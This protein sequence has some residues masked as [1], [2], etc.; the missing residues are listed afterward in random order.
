MGIDLN[1]AGKHSRTLA[2]GSSDE[3]IF[4][5]VIPRIYNSMDKRFEMTLKIEGQ[6]KTYSKNEFKHS[7]PSESGSHEEITKWT[8]NVGEICAK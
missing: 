6:M 2:A 8:I 5:D 1:E 7:F 3:L 4:K